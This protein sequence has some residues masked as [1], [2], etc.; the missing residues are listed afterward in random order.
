MTDK[1]SPPDTRPVFKKSRTPQLLVEEK[2]ITPET[3]KAFYEDSSRRDIYPGRLLLTGGYISRIK[4]TDFCVRFLKYPHIQL[5][6]KDVDRQVALLLKQTF[7]MRNFVLPIERNNSEIT[8][9][10]LDPHDAELKEYIEHQTGCTVR[11]V[12]ATDV[13]L[14]W[15]FHRLFGKTLV[16]R[17]VYDL[18]WKSPDESAALVVT[19]RQLVFLVLLTGLF[20][21]TLTFS[22]VTALVI[23]AGAINSFYMLSVLLK[24]ALTLAGA[25]YEM[26]EHVSR[27]EVRELVPEEL[28]VYTILVPLYK[29][30]EMLPQIAQ[31]LRRLDYPI[32]K[33]DIKLLLEENDND[34]LEALKRLSLP[35]TF[36]FVIV[37]DFGPKTK[38]KAC[39]YGL[40]L[41]RGKYVTIYDAEDIPEPDQLKKIV[42]L[43]R[44]E[45]KDVVCIQASL[46]YYNANEN[47]LTRMFT[48]EYSYWFDYMLRGLDNF[49]LPIPL[50]G[51]SNHFKVDRL[52]ELGGWDP[53]NVTEDADLGVR[54]YS[55]GYKIAVI[56]STTFEEANN[57]FGNWLRQRSRWVKGYMLTWLVHMRHP[58]RLM[59]NIGWKGFLGFNFFI[60]GTPFVFLVNPLLWI[61]FISWLVFDLTWMTAFFPPVVLYISL[62]NLLLGNLILIYMNMV[63][64]FKRKLYPLTVFALL[65]PVYWMLHTIAAYKALWQLIRDPFYWEK[66]THGTSKLTSTIDGNSKT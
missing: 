9:A 20:L 16:H 10:M 54:A 23:L 22:P 63:A 12:F 49:K 31:S 60:G 15:Q 41:A 65:N 25:Q 59:R 33:L 28:P 44:K 36:D 52:R 53:F 2:Y 4:Y 5:I 55:R 47:F 3:R 61:A 6:G 11:P 57:R 46:N 13:E 45:H 17:S 66:T 39:N 62:F 50:G 29:E 58:V 43:F 34:T 7:I 64:V 35:A 8:V 38:P 32:E 37:P 24:F 48:L 27:R 30:A 40:Y 21:L 56:D 26:T 51:T 14:A 18:F 42:A 19:N 1:I